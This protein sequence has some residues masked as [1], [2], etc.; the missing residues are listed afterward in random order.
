[1]ISLLVLDLVL[2][3]VQLSTYIIH[4]VHQ[5]YRV[6]LYVRMA[7]TYACE[8]FSLVF[9]C[10]VGSIPTRP[11]KAEMRQQQLSVEMLDRG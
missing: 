4:T 3:S 6:L 2:D 5:Y 10:L 1:M 7:C 8:G 11:F 9:D